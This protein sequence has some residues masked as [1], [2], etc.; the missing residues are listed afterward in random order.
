MTDGQANWND[1][2]ILVIGAG[3]MGASIAQAYAQNGFAVGLLDISDEILEKARE[4]IQRELDAARGRIFTDED[5]TGI[6]SRILTTTDYATAC[7][8]KN[9]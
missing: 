5:I 3:T 4:T 1:V 2:E 8:G 6:Q 7:G 9:L